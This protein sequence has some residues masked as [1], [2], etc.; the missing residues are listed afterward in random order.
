MDDKMYK[1]IRNKPLYHHNAINLLLAMVLS[2]SPKHQEDIG[3]I[4]WHL[5]KLKDYVNLDQR[6]NGRLQ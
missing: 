6:S 3:N 2:H 5:D 1:K 4:R